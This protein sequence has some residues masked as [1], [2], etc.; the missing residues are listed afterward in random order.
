MCQSLNEYV[1]KEKTNLIDDYWTNMAVEMA[2]VKL[3][4][5]LSVKIVKYREI[6]INKNF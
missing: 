1:K 2:V 3:V 4:I 5:E 6:P